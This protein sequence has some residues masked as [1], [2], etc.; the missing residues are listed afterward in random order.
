MEKYPW[1]L[2]ILRLSRSISNFMASKIGCRWYSLWIRYASPTTAVHDT[3]LFVTNY[4]IVGKGTGYKSQ[5]EW[6]F[7][8][9]GNR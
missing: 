6:E 9:D 2:T 4:Y 3:V 7:Y 8:D 5:D 1:W